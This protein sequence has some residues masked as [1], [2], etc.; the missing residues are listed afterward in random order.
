MKKLFSS[1]LYPAG[2]T[3]FVAWRNASNAGVRC[4]H[5]V[6]QSDHRSPTDPNHLQLNLRGFAAQLAMI[7]AGQYH[8]VSLQAYFAAY[9]TGRGLSDNLLLRSVDD[10]LRNFL[11][12]AVCIPPARAFRAQTVQ[13]NRIPTT[14]RGLPARE[15]RVNIPGRGR[16]CFNPTESL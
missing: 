3:R 4:R 11:T 1:L 16:L 5:G 2:G 9:E 15:P 13:A 7:L 8:A 12:S 10:G 14:S 6:T